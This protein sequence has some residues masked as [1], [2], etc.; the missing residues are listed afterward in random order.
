MY[1]EKTL[2]YFRDFDKE[3]RKIY[4]IAEEAKKT[5][6]DPVDKVEIPLAMS[7]FAA[8]SRETVFKSPCDLP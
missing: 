4:S 1:S 3:V 2:K 5:G 6:F 8:S 7:I